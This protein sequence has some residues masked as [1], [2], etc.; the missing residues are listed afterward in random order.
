MD[1]NVHLPR[2][3][4]R[5]DDLPGAGIHADVQLAP[6]LTR[7]GAMFLDQPLTRATAR[8]LSALR[9]GTAKASP[10]SWVDGANQ[11]LHAATVSSVNQTV[12]LPRWRRAASY[13]AELTTLRFCFGMR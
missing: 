13:T 8:R 10:S 4:R 1:G 7:P 3:Q 12:K 9:S 6:G 5:C 2:S 11:A